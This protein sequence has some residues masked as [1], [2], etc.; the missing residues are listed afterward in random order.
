M[1]LLGREVGPISVT[2]TVQ[3]INF[4]K[5]H[6]KI[7]C[8][9]EYNLEWDL[10]VCISAWGFCCLWAWGWAWSSG[11]SKALR[12]WLTSRWCIPASMRTSKLSRTSWTVIPMK[13]VERRLINTYYIGL[14]F[15]P[16]V[17]A[18]LGVCMYY[19][20]LKF[21]CTFSIYFWNFFSVVPLLRNSFVYSGV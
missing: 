6:L 5:I 4:K 15:L 18:Y 7:F 17:S 3:A 2:H 9:P 13:N 19:L 14:Q 8:N 16:P 20:L 11:E 10:P 1:R 12:R 21:L